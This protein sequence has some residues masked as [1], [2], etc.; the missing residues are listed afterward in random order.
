MD[1]TGLVE[2]CSLARLL[3]MEVSGGVSSVIPFTCADN[4]G[5]MGGFSC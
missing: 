2:R 5:I 3:F 4:I 1:C